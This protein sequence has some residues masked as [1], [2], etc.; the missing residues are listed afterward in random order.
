MNISP[1]ACWS[2]SLFLGFLRN[3]FKHTSESL[4]GSEGVLSLSLGSL[5]EF[6]L[7]HRM[8]V[9]TVQG[10]QDMG[11]GLELN[12]NTYS[13][14]TGVTNPTLAVGYLSTYIVRLL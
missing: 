4:I 13:M 5:G 11:E 10:S 8:V 9:G 7:V 1:G 3:R 6:L 14:P 12:V 2:G